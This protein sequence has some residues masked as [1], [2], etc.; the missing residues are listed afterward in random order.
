M[1]SSSSSPT[2]C[3]AT[4]IRWLPKK[5]RIGCLSPDTMTT[6]TA[7]RSSAYLRVRSQG[8]DLTET[9]RHGEEHTCRH[10]AGRRCF[11]R[12]G[13]SPMEVVGPI[14]ASSASVSE[15]D[16]AVPIDESPS[17]SLCLRESQEPSANT[18]FRA[19]GGAGFLGEV[20]PACRVNLV[21]PKIAQSDQQRQAA[22]QRFG[23]LLADKNGRPERSPLA[24]STGRPRV[25]FRP[26]EALT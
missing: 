3:R 8:N 15:C 26:R 9:R 1:S 19:G 6:G 13:Q 10:D 25:E 17:V 18:S 2:K 14:R 24:T 20:N 21:D 16:L 7:V 4:R 5:G 12:R 22:T 23:K 11:V